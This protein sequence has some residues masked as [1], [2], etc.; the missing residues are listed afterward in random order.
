MSLQHLRD[1]RTERATLPKAPPK[2]TLPK[3][4]TT[5][6]NTTRNTNTNTNT[7]RNTN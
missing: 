7:T 3:R 2:A 1:C 4:E 6:R 5:T